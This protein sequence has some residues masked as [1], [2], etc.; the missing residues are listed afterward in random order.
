MPRAR[1]GVTRSPALPGRSTI[2]ETYKSWR[3]HSL[4]SGIST[5]AVSEE[6]DIRFT[7]SV[8]VPSTVIR[9]SP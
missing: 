3:V 2:T 7:Q 6:M 5:V 1:A 8:R 4:L 9:A